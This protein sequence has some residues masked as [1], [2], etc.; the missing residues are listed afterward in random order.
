MK[1]SVPLL[2]LLLATPLTVLA[3]TASPY[4][5]PEVF[6]SKANSIT[7]QSAITVEKFYVPA[8]NFKTD[9]ELTH[10][11]GRKSS[12]AAAAS[13]SRMNVAEAELPMDGTYRIRTINSVGNSADYAQLDGHWIRIRAPRPN[14]NMNSNTTEAKPNTQPAVASTT[15]DANQAKTASSKAITAK[16]PPRFLTPEQV[17]AGAKRMSSLNTPIAETFVSKAKPSALSQLPQPTGQGLELKLLSHPNQAFL[18]DDFK[19]QV[20]FNGQPVTDLD[21]D[22]FLGANAYDLNAKRELPHAKTDV[23]GELTVPLKSA[24]IYLI[25]FAYPE[26]AASTTQAP[27]AQTYSY[28]L[29][30]EVTE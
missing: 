21:V 3:H 9:Y 25:S 20:L 30:F 2:S 5:L 19:A 10:P 6:D 13:L 11:D 27:A 26:A 14:N 4:I 23:K 12:I 18:G 7:W 16:A 24:G 17:P 8:R 1:I 22:V 15:T 29:S 28:G